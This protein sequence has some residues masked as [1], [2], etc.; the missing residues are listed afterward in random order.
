M[1][2]YKKEEC[3][4]NQINDNDHK[5]RHHNGARRRTANLLGAGARGEAFEAA[6]GGD[7]DTK[8]NAL[9]ESGDNITEEE[10]VKRSRYVASE[11]EISLRYA[12]KRAAENAHGIGPNGEAGQHDGHGDEFW[13]NEEMDRADGH[14]FEGVDFLGDLHRA[15]FGGE[16]GTG[17]ADYDDGG[18]ERPE[19]ARHGD[20]DSRR[21]VADGSK[22]TELVSSLES[23]DQ[24]DKKSDEGEDGDSADADVERLR[25]GALKANGLAL[26][27]S[28]EGVVGGLATER[29]ES[30]DVGQ[31]V[32]YG[33]ADLGENLHSHSTRQS[34]ALKSLGRG[35]MR[36]IPLN[37]QD[38]KQ[39]TT[40]GDALKHAP[41]TPRSRLIQEDKA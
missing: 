15:Y 2:A 11:G 24:A 40:A 22:A 33:T 27:G 38:N 39:V 9:D 37:S 12:E 16:G 30:A 41:T 19:F 34:L 25:D 35:K 1:L 32:G 23:E 17:T 5:N 31:T 10:R 20:G 29:G 8:H 3:S 26:K 7:G 21:H 18:D 28:Y 4:E 36:R 13:R 6:D 14:G